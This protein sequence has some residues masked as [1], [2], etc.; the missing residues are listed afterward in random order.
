MR[1]CAAMTVEG[2]ELTFCHDRLGPV[3]R[4]PKGKPHLKDECLI[5]T[6]V[7]QDSG[8]WTRLESVCRARQMNLLGPDCTVCVV[9]N[10][11]PVG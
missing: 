4:C 11:N 8:I 2:M 3:D 9:L 7:E 10:N 6:T 1:C 5:E